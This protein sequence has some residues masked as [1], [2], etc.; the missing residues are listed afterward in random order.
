MKWKI[1]TKSTEIFEDNSVWQTGESLNAL[2]RRTGI[3]L[4]LLSKVKNG[5]VILSKETADKYRQKI[6]G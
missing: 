2:H 5:K 4:S 3:A 1:V 6:L